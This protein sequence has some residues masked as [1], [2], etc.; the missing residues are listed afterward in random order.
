MYASV[1]Y[2]IECKSF[3]KIGECWKHNFGKY[4]KKLPSGSKNNC[5]QELQRGNPF[6]LNVLAFIE[7]IEYDNDIEF[8]SRKRPKSQAKEDHL[9]KQFDHLKHRDE[10]YR[11][12][13]ELRAYIKNNALPY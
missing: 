9:H 5:V 6:Q 7:F 12:T 1:V 10:W 13:S 3:I 2:F 11:D 8:N 4:S